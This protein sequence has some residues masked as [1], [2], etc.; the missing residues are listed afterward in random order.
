MVK[1]PSLQ[2][3]PGLHYQKYWPIFQ[4]VYWLILVLN[5]LE[6]SQFHNIRKTDILL[7]MM[8][9]KKFKLVWIILSVIAGAA[10]II[11]S[12]LPL[13]TSLR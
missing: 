10:I 1:E 8:Y 12:F 7:I 9:S 3:L 4:S 6:T 13:L 11:F 5:I 2:R